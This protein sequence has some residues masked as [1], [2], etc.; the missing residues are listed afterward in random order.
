MRPGVR[1]RPTRGSTDSR[2]ES[3]GRL[4][5]AQAPASLGLV[6]QLSV[7]IATSI[8]GYIAD[9]DGRLDWLDDA[10]LPGEDQGYQAFY[11]SV[12]A[13]AMGSGTYDF[14]KDHEPWPFDK[15]IYVFSSR[16]YPDRAGVTFWNRSPLEAAKHWD[17]SGFAK[18]YVDGGRLISSFLE[19]GLIDDM[20]ISTA[21]VL[22]GGGS[23]LFRSHGRYARARLIET[24]SW[25]SG[26]VQNSYSFE[27]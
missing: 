1:R 11:D 6:P 21:P 26:Y 22:L 15:P 14:I 7:F 18:V 20:I 24:R 4:L 17:T 3:I 10:L 23:P 12:D 8:D 25:P 27:N 19:Q 2:S 5:P 13:L 9:R 16:S